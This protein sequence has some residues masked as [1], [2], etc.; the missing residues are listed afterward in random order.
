MELAVRLN[1][2]DGFRQTLLFGKLVVIV[3]VARFLFMSCLRKSIK[4]VERN[5]T[6]GEK[7]NSYT[8]EWMK[9]CH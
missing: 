2:R 9:W 5:W 8:N 1:A 7:D 4:A 6:Q 3:G